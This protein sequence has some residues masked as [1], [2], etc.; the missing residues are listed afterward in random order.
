MHHLQDSSHFLLETETS[1]VA[2]KTPWKKFWETTLKS[3]LPHK[4]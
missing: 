2:I 4:L 3:S 1:D